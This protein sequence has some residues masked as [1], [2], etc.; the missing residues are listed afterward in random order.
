MSFSERALAHMASASLDPNL[1]P[2]ESL[3]SF[4]LSEGF[5]DFM[6]REMRNPFDPDFHTALEIY[7]G[8]N[9]LRQIYMDRRDVLFDIG[10]KQCRRTTIPLTWKSLRD[11]A[12]GPSRE[13]IE[14]L[15]DFGMRNGVVLIHR[16]INREPIFVSV[17]GDV[18][19]ELSQDDLL[20]VQVICSHFLGLWLADYPAS[21]DD[22]KEL[23]RRELEILAASSIGLNGKSLED[24]LNISSHTMRAHLRSIR[25][26]LGANSM[27]HAV[28]IGMR[29]GLLDS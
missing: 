2:I 21:I 16:E 24:H 22:V 9:E 17:V 19:N 29:Y 13:I 5:T 28:N 14:Y 4:L 23:S 1:A 3:K 12:T 26:K 20:M 18:V 8:P 10:M 27:P 7:N 15:A 25:Q 11:G 6:A